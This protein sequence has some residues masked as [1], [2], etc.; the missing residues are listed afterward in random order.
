VDDRSQIGSRAAE[1][2]EARSPL[3]S[4]STHCVCDELPEGQRGPAL[5]PAASRGRVAGS[6]LALMS[7]AV[8]VSL[9]NNYFAQPLIDTIRVEFGVSRGVAGLIV[10]AAQCGYAAGLVFLIPLGDLL[11]RR[12]LV[13]ILALLT[14]GFLVFAGSAP[15]I[16][17]LLPAVA[18]VALTSVMAQ[19]LVPFAA[20][21]AGERERGRVVGTVMSGLI[22]GI[23]LARTA[24]GAIAQ[25]AGWRAVYFIA[26][27]LM[28]CVAAMLRWR[29]PRFRE[30]VRLSYSGLLRSVLRIARVEPVLRRRA[31][32]GGL[33]FAAFTTLWTTLAFQLA[34]PPYT[35]EDG[36]IGLFGLVGA[37]GALVASAAGRLTDRGWTDR[38]TVLMPLAM[39]ASYG[40]IWLGGTR[41]WALLAGIVLIDIGAQGIHI[42]NQSVIFGLRP[43]ARSRINS[44]YMTS[45]FIGA[46][47]GSS[48][49]SFVYAAFGWTAMCILGACLAAGITLARL[50]DGVTA[51]R[52]TAAAE[53]AGR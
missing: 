3:A 5:V 13:T 21:L 38:L 30:D 28:V 48:S 17:V 31:L 52:R 24:S 14:A 4:P 35:Y 20:S 32:Y 26:A 12:R 10:T 50:T 7:V 33:S 53:A 47:V 43:D 2:E 11:E 1:P 37:V 15:S 45:C 22:L 34:G 39:V 25:V 18:L 42:T 51:R 9:A 41:L 40:L 6:L 46:A 19:I 8:G 23:L 44:V 49:A 27:G 36:V 16:G 29:L